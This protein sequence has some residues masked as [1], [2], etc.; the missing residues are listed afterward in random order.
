MIVVETLTL[1]K[2]NAEERRENHGRNRDG[3]MKRGPQY[4]ISLSF[5]N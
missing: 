2:E 5:S 4:H 3:S 1:S